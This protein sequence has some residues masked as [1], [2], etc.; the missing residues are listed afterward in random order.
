[1]RDEQEEKRP[2]KWLVGVLAVAFVAAVAGLLWS[3]SLAGR[4]T[5]AEAQL[6]A[7]QQQNQQLAKALNETNAKLRTTRE[8]LGH[9]LGATQRELRR[10]AQELLH[11]QQAAAR[12]LQQ[13]QQ[14]TQTQVTSVTSDVGGVA[15]DLNLTKSQLAS[16]EARMKTMQGDLGV[17]SG[18]IA[19]NG[20]ELQVLEQLGERDYFP[21]TLQKGKKQ[22][23]ATVALELRHV[24][25]K[26]RTYTM[27]IYSG[28]HRIEK[29]N[30]AL[31]EPVQ[32]YTGKQRVLYELV[33]NKI[34]RNEVRGYIAAPK[35]AVG[36]KGDG[37]PPAANGGAQ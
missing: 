16:D 2:S 29:K 27:T 11:R 32:F 25:G 37:V 20:R 7:T 23:V 1:M 17:E 33:V 30:R 36:S 10:R 18:L 5:H 9:R 26:H 3:Y 21:F 34:A 22:A 35:A 8:T 13:E 15:T 19:T 28:K 4:L 14:S 6:A 31:D 12:Q 24:N